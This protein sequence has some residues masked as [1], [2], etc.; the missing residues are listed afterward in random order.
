MSEGVLTFPSTVRATI[1]STSDGAYGAVVHKQGRPHSVGLNEVQYVPCRTRR[2]AEAYIATVI[3]SVA[4][5]YMVQPKS[6]E[7]NITYTF[8]EAV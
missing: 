1:F 8:T 7:Y 2:E 3:G 6:V 5:A 4:E